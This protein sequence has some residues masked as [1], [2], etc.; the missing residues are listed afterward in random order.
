MRLYDSPGCREAR[1]LLCHGR[2][3][4]GTFKLRAVVAAGATHVQI[5]SAELALMLEGIEL[6]GARR[7]KRYSPEAAE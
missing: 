1:A 2:L 4:A 7:R 6:A 5:D 3:E